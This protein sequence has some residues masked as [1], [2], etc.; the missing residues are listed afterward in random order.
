MRSKASYIWLFLLAVAL[1]VF[2]FNNLTI[3][4]LL[5]V[6]VYPIFILSQPINTPQVRIILLATLLGVT[7]DILCGG[8]GLYT[9]SCVAS[10]ACRIAILKMMLRHREV[11]DGATPSPASLEQ[12]GYLLFMLLYMTIHMAI[13]LGVESL[14]IDN[15]NFIVLRYVISLAASLIFVLLIQRVTRREIIK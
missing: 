6:H 1:Q 8:A 10:S 12:R 13:F 7:L 4:L 9:I 15:I 14:G 11:I 2:L 3:S 5:V